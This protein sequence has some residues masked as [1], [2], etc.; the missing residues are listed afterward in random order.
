MDYFIDIGYR[1][2]E[3]YPNSTWSTLDGNIFFTVNEEYQTRFEA[4]FNAGAAS[5]VSLETNMYGEISVGAK[6]Y[7]FFIDSA[8]HMHQISFLWEEMPITSDDFFDTL[9]EYELLTLAIDYKS[10]SHF[11]VKV[12]ESKITEIQVGEKLHFYRV[13]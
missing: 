5:L 9:E 13:N 4:P 8:P 7:N 1:A 6:K 12:N 2:P 10:K 3:N 11:A